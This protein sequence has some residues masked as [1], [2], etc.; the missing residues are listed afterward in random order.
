[1]I[2]QEP[3]CFSEATLI[4]QFV[5]AT[6]TEYHLRMRAHNK[7]LAVKVELIHDAPTKISNLLGQEINATVH[8]LCISSDN[9]DHYE[10]VRGWYNDYVHDFIAKQQ[11]KS[12]RPNPPLL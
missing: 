12:I 4:A 11:T 9:P 3:V 8:R 5:F 10:E 7:G 2:E 6:T 1:M